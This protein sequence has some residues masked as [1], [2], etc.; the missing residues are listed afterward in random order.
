MQAV[1][2]SNIES[3]GHDS[4][5]NVLHV[6]FKNGGT[7]TYQGVD[8]RKFLKLKGAE[9]VGSHLHQEIKPN[10]KVTKLS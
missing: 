4:E 5:N 6:K 10:H 7:Y 9:S 8:T 3:I 1:Q 2:S